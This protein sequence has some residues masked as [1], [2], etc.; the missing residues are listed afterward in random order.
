MQKFLHTI[1][2]LCF[3]DIV[4]EQFRYKNVTIYKKN[5]L[6]Q[7]QYQNPRNFSGKVARKSRVKVLGIHKNSSKQGSTFFHVDCF[8]QRWKTKISP[9]VLYNKPIRD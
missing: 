5:V 2:S 6:P 1:R 3:G 4:A 7:N 9:D 8:K